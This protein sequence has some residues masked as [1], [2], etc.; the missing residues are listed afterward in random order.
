MTGNPQRLRKDYSCG[1]YYTESI[2]GRPT[3]I[4]M[5]Q[6][7]LRMYVID[8]YEGLLLVDPIDKK[9]EVLV[10]EIEKQEGFHYLTDLVVSRHTGRVYF[11]E[12]S[13]THRRRDYV[14]AH[15][16]AASTGRLLMYNPEMA[17]IEVIAGKLVCPTSLT[18]VEGKDGK[19]DDYILIA[20]GPRARVRQYFLPTKTREGTMSKSTFVSN[21]P[22]LPHSIQYDP[23]TDALWVG[24][25][26]RREQLDQFSRWPKARKVMSLVPVWIM[27]LVMPKQAALLRLDPRKGNTREVFADEDGVLTGAMKFHVQGDHVYIASERGA[28]DGIAKVPLK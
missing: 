12:A 19:S 17:T 15:Y 28:F 18:I 3:G 5:D 4:S 11:L 20:E 14:R 25:D 7:G 2:C 9:K 24:G 1:T 6:D 22:V 23:S 27:D 8:S 26:M 21:L 10:Y 13:V 16:E